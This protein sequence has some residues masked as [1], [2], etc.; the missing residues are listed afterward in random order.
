MEQTK[1]P[2]TIFYDG[3]C[4]VCSAEMEHY[5]RKDHGGRLVFVDIGSPD[6]RP[7]EHGKSLAEFMARMHLCDAQG[8][9][10]SGIEAFQAIWRACPGPW[11]PAA[12]RLIGLPGLN[13]L[14]QL[15]YA[16]FARYRYLL[17]KKDC[18]AGA[19]DPG[20]WRR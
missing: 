3:A 17:P 19:C 15:G 7:Q 8:D 5:R 10:V 11:L 20:R 13:Q 14:A 18:K 1:Y 6:F 16:L 9:F 2:L 12:A 4:R